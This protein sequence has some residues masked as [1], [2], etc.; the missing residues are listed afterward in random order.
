MR[1]LDAALARV[2][3]DFARELRLDQPGQDSR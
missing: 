2:L 3:E 1:R